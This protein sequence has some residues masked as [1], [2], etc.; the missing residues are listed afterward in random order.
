MTAHDEVSHTTEFD[1]FARV[2]WDRAL[3]LALR[4][5]HNRWDAEDVVAEAMTNLW[6]RWQ[7]VPI[8]DPWA[9]LLRSVHNGVV[10]HSRA[11]HRELSALARYGAPDAVAFDESPIEHRDQ[12]SEALAGLSPTHQRAVAMR[13]LFDLSGDELARKLGVPAATAK[14][15]AWRGLARLRGSLVT[16]AA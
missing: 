14:S 15:Q 7:V 6:R 3:R 10:D 9:Y 4:M 1:D 2:H 8:N 12:L 11:R 13:Y 5:I 16:E